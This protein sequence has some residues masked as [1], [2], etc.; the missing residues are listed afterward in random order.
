M[1][2]AE[3]LL[4]LYKLLYVYRLLLVYLA[5][6]SC[7]CVCADSVS[8]DWIGIT[9]FFLWRLPWYKLLCRC[10]GLFKMFSRCFF[11][12]IWNVSET[13]DLDLVHIKT[14]QNISANRP[15][16]NYNLCCQ[17]KVTVPKKNLLYLELL[18]LDQMLFPRK[19]RMNYPFL[20]L[21]NSPG[22]TG[23]L[24]CNAENVDEQGKWCPAK[25]ICR[26]IVLNSPAP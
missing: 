21:Q 15:H 8:A 22:T 5:V 6:W 12:S 24:G 20:T 26:L 7:F 13:I 19:W 23:S 16:N 2:I 14:F 4:N 17:Y 10:I 18:A 9:C 25:S 3:S 1:F 11:F